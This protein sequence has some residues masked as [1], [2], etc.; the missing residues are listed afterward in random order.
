MPFSV[1]RTVYIA[2]MWS[3]RFSS[4]AMTRFTRPRTAAGDVSPGA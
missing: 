1:S 4:L 3:P 2:V